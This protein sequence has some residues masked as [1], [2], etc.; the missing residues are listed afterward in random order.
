MIPDAKRIASVR[1][2]RQLPFFRD[3]Y[4]KAMPKQLYDPLSAKG[5]DISYDNGFYNIGIPPH[6]AAA[7]KRGESG[8]LNYARGGRVRRGCA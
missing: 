1:D 2:Q 3:V 5:F 4:D 6:L 8:P 7:I